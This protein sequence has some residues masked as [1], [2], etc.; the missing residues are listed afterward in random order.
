MVFVLC[1]FCRDIDRS[2]TDYG[3]FYADPEKVP[4]IPETI[5]ATLAAQLTTLPII[6]HVFGC[7]SILSILANVLIVPV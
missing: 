7:F 1:R 4:M 3:Y 2:T 5:I 6:M